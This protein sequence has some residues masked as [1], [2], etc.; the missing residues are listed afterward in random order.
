MRRPKLLPHVAIAG[1][2]VLTVLGLTAG[3]RA[4]AYSRSL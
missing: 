4:P 2:A 3:A 1:I